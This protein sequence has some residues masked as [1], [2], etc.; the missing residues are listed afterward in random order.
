MTELLTRLVASNAMLRTKI[1]TMNKTIMGQA[2]VIAEL[3][4]RMK[5]AEAEIKLVKGKQ[6]K[7]HTRGQDE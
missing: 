1:K 6:Y 3:S 2:E 5:K 4:D 7:K